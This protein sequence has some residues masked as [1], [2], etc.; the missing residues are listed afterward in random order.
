MMY[1]AL[2]E[3]LDLPLGHVGPPA[4]QV[5]RDQMQISSAALTFMAEKGDNIALQIVILSQR[6]PRAIAVS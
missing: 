4:R 2:A 1:V 3:A 5:E 6:N